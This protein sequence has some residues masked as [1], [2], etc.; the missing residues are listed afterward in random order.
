MC[1][2][3]A[4]SKNKGGKMQ[5]ATGGRRVG[6][7]EVVTLNDSSAGGESVA[8]SATCSSESRVPGEQHVEVISTV[9]IEGSTGSALQGG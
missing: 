3:G 6:G 8:A 5:T 7:T 2:Q 9:R 1:I 4:S